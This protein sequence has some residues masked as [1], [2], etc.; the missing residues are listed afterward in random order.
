[1]AFCGNHSWQAPFPLYTAA[2]PCGISPT[3]MTA[4]IL[5]MLRILLAEL[6]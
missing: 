4:Q 5:H 3:L 2:L 6:P 1:M